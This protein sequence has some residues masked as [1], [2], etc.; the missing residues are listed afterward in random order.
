MRE[1]CSSSDVP[2]GTS[3]GFKISESNIFI[4]R[5]DGAVYCYE[6]TC[7]HLGI[8]LE[9]KPD[10]FLDA[11][12]EL[13]QCSTHGALFIISSGECVSGPCVG[14]YLTPLDVLEQD[15]TVFLV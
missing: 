6:N 13:I 10:A 7:P 15:G 14:N 3:K 5:R 4:V 9:W 12:G 2:E 11:E 8:P 1:L